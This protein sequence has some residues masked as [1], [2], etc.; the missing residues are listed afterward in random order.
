MKKINLQVKILSYF[1]LIILSIFLLMWVTVH[2]ATS[3]Y[4]TTKAKNE[5]D[6]ASKIVRGLILKNEA[7]DMD[8][9]PLTLKIQLRS[10]SKVSQ[11][12]GDTN[13][14][15]ISDKKNTILYPRDNLSTDTEA[16]LPSALMS[17]M[18]EKYPDY[19]YEKLYKI[20]VQDSEYYIT[21]YKPKIGGYIILLFMDISIFNN[22]VGS[23]NIVLILVFLIGGLLAA[24][25][26][27][28]ISNRISKPVQ[29]LCNYAN[30]ISKGN[31]EAR[32]FNFHDK[33][34]AGLAQDMNKM[35]LQLKEHDAEQKQFFQ[36]VS[37]DLRTPLMSI[38]GYAEGILHEVFTRPQEIAAVIVDECKRLT[39]MV[40]DILFLSKWNS[41][42]VKLKDEQIILTDMLQS[43]IT[44]ANGIAI[45]Q[46]KSIITDINT[47]AI[48]IN[49]DEQ[50]LHRAFLNLLSNCIRYSKRTVTISLNIIQKEAQNNDIIEVII[51]DDGEGFS[52]EDLN[53]LFKRN[54]KGTRGEFGIGLVIAKTIF[55]YHNTS[56][57]PRNNK[58][59]GGAEFVCNIPLNTKH[60]NIFE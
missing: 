52:H 17:E 11:F 9:F 19:K 44:T 6:A 36:N 31:F 13:F 27:L 8:K 25:C 53:N 29:V 54:Y 33:E 55:D 7:N 48:I 32:N 56:I 10:I 26:S 21:A 2:V 18:N 45:K 20:L 60:I 58:D 51:R 14:I 15:I 3:R 16:S 37:H 5:L 46:N 35:A 4:I 49:G 50:Y 59:D 12:T 41:A 43:V 23:I 47:Q 34:F 1:L 24:L 57:F 40:N 22:F 30:A 42:G 39:S 38:Q 28:W